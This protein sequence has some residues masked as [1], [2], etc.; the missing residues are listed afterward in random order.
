[1]YVIHCGGATIYDPNNPQLQILSGSLKT[2]VNLAGTLTFSLPPGHP[3]LDR[4]KIRACVVVVYRDDVRYFWGAPITVSADDDNIT[5]VVVEGALAWL[6][7]SVQ[8]Y[9]EYHNI[10][11]ELYLAALLSNHNSVTED[12]KHFTAGIVSVTDSNDSLY[13][14]SNFEKTKAAISDK[15]VNR[16]GGYLRVRMENGTQYLD[17][18]ADYTHVNTQGV[19]FGQNLLTYAKAL[20]S[21]NLATAIIPLGAKLTDESGQQ[22]EERLQIDNDGKNYVWDADAVAQYGWIFDTEICDDV[23]LVT[24]LIQRGYKALNERKYLSGTIKLTAV[25]F[26]A[27]GGDY[28]HITVGDLLPVISAPHDIDTQIMVCE[29]VENLVDA[30]NSTV[31]LSKAYKT[32]TG[33]IVESNR[34]NAEKLEIARTE[35]FTRIESVKQQLTDY[36]TDVSENLDSITSA[37]SETQHTITTTTENI[38][39]ALGELQDTI[40][41]T[42]ELEQMKQ[43][44]IS[45]WSDALEMRFTTV[46]ELINN[47]NGTIDE[48]QRLL[49]EYIRFEGARIELGRSDSNLKAVLTNEKLA[50]V[51]NG[52][53]VAYISNQ[54]MYITDVHIVRALTFGNADVGNY[55]FTLGE[56]GTLDLDFEAP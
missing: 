35:N 32:M 52:Q 1:M 18:L 38:Y 21:A 39:N 28:E 44:L 20:A 15:L 49:E 56:N 36:K 10:T 34:Q 5:T 41:S 6:N 42:D 22:T 25:D 55:M 53:E 3:Y 14:K 29:M 9:G 12:Y 23:T 30:G 24:N 4:I 27:L 31:T 26:G 43:L 48:N 45:Q 16:L 7:D 8:P 51:E 17:Y 13:R 50:F 19:R 54:K 2:G 33:S 46:Q 47:T 11:L 37:V 40:V